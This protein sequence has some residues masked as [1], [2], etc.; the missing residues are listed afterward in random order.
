MQIDLD[1]DAIGRNFPV[2]VGLHADATLAVPALLAVLGEAD[3]DP[4]WAGQVRAA[5]DAARA[6]HRDDIGAYSQICDSMRSRLPR[7]GVVV[8]DV[9]IPGSSWGNRLLPVYDPTSNIYAAGGGIGQGLA[10]AIGA[11]VARRETPVLAMIGDGGLAVHLGELATLAGEDVPVIVTLFND[12]GYG[13]LRNMQ[14]A[15]DAPHRA[16]DLMTPDFAGLCAS[17]GIAHTAVG[18][19]D[20]YDAALA[21]AIER[22]GP[23]VIEIDVAALSPAP[24]PLVPPVN[25]P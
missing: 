11:A 7:D 6:A 2:A 3:T 24:E 8:R 20:S 10:Q 12:G 18:G 23:A 21:E 17:F 9:C 15:K 5:A 13:V 16:V 4:E 19:A 1:A 25:V 22:G 14:S